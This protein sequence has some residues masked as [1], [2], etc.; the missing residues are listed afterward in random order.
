VIALF[1]ALMVVA[2]LVLQK[3]GILDLQSGMISTTSDVGPGGVTNPSLEAMGGPVFLLLA[4]V[5][6]FLAWRVNAKGRAL[7]SFLFVWLLQL[8]ALVIVQPYLNVSGYRIDKTFYVLIFPMAILATLPLARVIESAAAWIALTPR[9]AVRGFVVA[10]LATIIGVAVLRPPHF[11]SPFSEAE[12]QTALWANEHL[13]TYQLSYLDP[14]MLRAYWV[15]FGFWRETLPTEWFQWIPAG[16]KLGPPTFEE[17]LNDPSWPRWIFLPDLNAQDV[18]PAQVI[19]QSG[20]SGIAQKDSQKFAAQLPQYPVRWFYSSWI[21]MRGFDLPR[22]T[23]SPG[24]AITL[25]TYTESVTPPSWTVGW[26]VSLVDRAGQI[27]SRVTG[28]P[29]AGKYPV[30][31]WPPNMLARDVWD[32]PLDPNLPPGAYELKMG[33]YRR[34][35][36]QE[37]EVFP[38]DRLTGAIVWNK[39]LYSGAAS[40]AKIKVRL[41]PPPAEELSAATMLR[42][43]VGDDISLS[44]YALQYSPAT[45]SVHLTLYWA[46]LAKTETDYTVFVHVLDSGGALVAQKDAPPLGGAYPTSIWDPDEI[47]KDPYDLVIP[48]EAHGPFSIEIGM[49][50]Q[51]GLRRLPVGSGDHI[52]LS[53]IAQ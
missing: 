14:Q 40:L 38:E 8:I 16:T 44:R 25:T 7:L 42:A 29:F 33:L 27:V 36:G 5:G 41:A 39:L 48:G 19:F 1:I 11:Y 23:F 46:G 43:R 9:A 47:V 35:N 51:P 45:R 15:A 4:F 12:I 28:D 2:A 34:D 13:D 10:V 32:L 31:R 18:A 37:F 20:S 17:W 6:V 21:K 49:Y 3:A 50:T 53:N 26:R 52:T 30:Q 22:S 24:E